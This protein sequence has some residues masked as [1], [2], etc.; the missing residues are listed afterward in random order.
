MLKFNLAAHLKNHLLSK[1]N[2]LMN[3]EIHIK[4][5]G[6][7]KG[8]FSFPSMSNKLR[9]KNFDRALYFDGSA[10][11]IP[12]FFRSSETRASKALAEVHCRELE[13]FKRKVKASKTQ[14]GVVVLY[15]WGSDPL[16][17]RPLQS[18][19]AFVAA[20]ESWIFLNHA[21]IKKAINK[22]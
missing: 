1:T 15:D 4:R 9:P 13:E 17:L 6:R 18:K 5:I 19:L 22:L 3:S 20:D 7:N 21:R 11:V 16:S 12:S 14:N 8:S 10:D 2:I